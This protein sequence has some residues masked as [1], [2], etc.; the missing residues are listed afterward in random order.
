MKAGTRTVT[1]GFAA[2]AATILMWQLGYHQPD[3][4]AVAPVGLEAA[5]TGVIATV[6]S[7]ICDVVV[8]FGGR[9]HPPA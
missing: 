1:V 3:M 9:R 2:G 8:W 5:I 4:M 7:A 6:A